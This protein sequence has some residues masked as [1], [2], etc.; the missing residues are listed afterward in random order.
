MCVLGVRRV[1]DGEMG[2]RCSASSV[3]V[4]IS[5]TWVS[6]VDMSSSTTT[7]TGRLFVTVGSTKFD[8]LV[9]EVLQDET[10]E[11]FRKAGLTE[12]VVQCGN[13]ALPLSLSPG[14]ETQKHGVRL[15]IWK[16]KPSLQDEIIKADLIISHAGGFIAYSA[17]SRLTSMNRLRDHHRHS[18]I[19]L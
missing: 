16:F 19:R 2:G 6:I 1:K 7:T 9:N 15:E 5:P 8:A 14:S 13:S 18:T 17:L 3:Q 4:A 12:V 10:L 11:A